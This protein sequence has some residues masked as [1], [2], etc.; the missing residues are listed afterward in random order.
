MLNASKDDEVG[1][2]EAGKEGRESY[3]LVYC[4]KK[5]I[6]SIVPTVSAGTMADPLLYHT[7]QPPG[8]FPSFL[9]YFGFLLA[10]LLFSRALN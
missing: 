8:T 2:G 4:T 9:F 6:S 7:Q 10:V 3:Q 5:Q 1:R